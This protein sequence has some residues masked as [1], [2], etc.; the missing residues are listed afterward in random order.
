VRRRAS[1][2]GRKCLM[3]MAR[4]ARFELTTSVFGG[5]WFACRGSYFAVLLMRDGMERNENITRLRGHSADASRCC[6]G[7]FSGQGGHAARRS[8]DCL[9]RK[10]T[11]L[12]HRGRRAVAGRGAVAGALAV[13][14]R[15]LA[16]LRLRQG[17]GAYR[18]D[19]VH[20]QHYHRE[21]SNANHLTPPH[22]CQP[23]SGSNR[24][25]TSGTNNHKASA[26]ESIAALRSHLAGPRWPA[27]HARRF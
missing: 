13:A 7:P 15:A 20:R 8:S 2:L 25:C 21:H 12:G 6:T 1:R 9:G 22:T 14:R 11:A 16:D 3:G 4:P 27:S 10:W 26:L 19:R 24:D 17:S 5:L 18:V 23:S